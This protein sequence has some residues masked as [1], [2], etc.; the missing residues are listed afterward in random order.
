MKGILTLLFFTYS[1]VVFAQQKD[2]VVNLSI[3]N[4]DTTIHKIVDIKA[5]FPGGEKKWNDFV[6]SKIENHVGALINDPRSRGTCTL[7]F[8]V[9]ADGKI[10]DVVA[11]NMQETELARVFVKA[12]KKGPSWIPAKINGQNVRSLHIQKVTFKTQ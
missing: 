6:K 3:P 9:N 5:Q 2:S 12:I 7:Q 11:L 4:N 8:V 1:L 10:S